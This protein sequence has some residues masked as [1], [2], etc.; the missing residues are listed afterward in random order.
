VGCSEGS[1]GVNINAQIA[2]E[3][4]EILIIGVAYVRVRG[5]ISRDAGASQN[6]RQ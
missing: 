4:G 5:L 3:A 6:L 2:I 1:R